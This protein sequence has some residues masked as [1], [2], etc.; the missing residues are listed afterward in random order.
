MV[1]RMTV[2][3]TED[4]Y[5]LVEDYAKKSGITK[6]KAVKVFIDS[7]VTLPVTA[8]SKEQ[9]NLVFETSPILKDVRK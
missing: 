2:W 9:T 6:H 8:E 4:Q 7:Y 1:K 3:L 5:R